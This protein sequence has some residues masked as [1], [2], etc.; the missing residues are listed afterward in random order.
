MVVYY[1]EEMTTDSLTRSSYPTF[2]A[3]PQLDAF[4]ATVL[5]PSSQSLA[6]RAALTTTSET[7]Y[8]LRDMGQ[9]IGRAIE[10]ENRE[11]L[12]NNLA[13][14]GEAYEIG[15]QSSSESAEGE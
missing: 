4:P 11:N 10:V 13:E 6:I 12:L 1:N 2:V 14:L 9:L 15:W 3:F 8:R 5:G 7:S